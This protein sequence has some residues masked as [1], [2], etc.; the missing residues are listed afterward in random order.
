MGW[1]GNWRQ[2]AVQGISG[3]NQWRTWLK[4]SARAEEWALKALRSEHKI[5]ELEAKRANSRCRKRKKD[6][7]VPEDEEEGY[8]SYAESLDDDV[9]AKKCRAGA[10]DSDSEEDC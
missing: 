2:E 9:P 6:S 5:D 1:L 8:V 7:H 3:W 10:D 4:K